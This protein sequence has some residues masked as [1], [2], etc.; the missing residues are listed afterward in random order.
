M[1]FRC[2]FTIAFCLCAS[3]VQA[4]AWP[5]EKGSSFF[6]MSVRL[7]WPQDVTHWISNDPTD[8]YRTAYFEY[9]LTDK[10][11]LGFDLGNS[12][13]GDGKAIGF[14]QFPLRNQDTGPKV[15]LQFGLGQISGDRVVRPGL[16]I[17]W[18]LKK[19]W[20]GIESFMEMRADTGVS[21]YKVDFTWGRNLAKDRKLI[22]QLQTG[23]QHGDPA[24]ARI[25]PSVVF[26]VHKRIK[27]ETGATY[28]LTGDSSMGLK[29]GF[30]TEF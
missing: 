27:L 20:I 24:F 19:G 23:I 14:V 10:V 30:W 21:D 2:L 26:P 29:L 8:Q 4:G 3:F 18:G 28:G 5:R 12:V 9:G 13:S 25:A 6:S 7:G 16:S 17:G 22:M 15:A 1:L 11:T